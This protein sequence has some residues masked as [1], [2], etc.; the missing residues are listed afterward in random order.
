MVCFQ[1]GC[2]LD[3]REPVEARMELLRVVLAPLCLDDPASIS[4]AGEQTLVA[5]LITQQH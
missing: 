2:K 1:A 4:Q 3:R 5:V